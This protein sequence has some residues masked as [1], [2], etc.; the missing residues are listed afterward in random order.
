MSVSRADETELVCAAAR[1]DD[2]AFTEL[3]GRHA[4]ALF[5]HALRAT[6]N[7]DDAQDIVQDVF[8]IAFRRRKNIRVIDGSAAG[9]L[10]ATCRNT[11][12]NRLR[13]ARRRESTP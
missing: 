5:A 1:G 7:E 3:M 10:L 2:A 6:G 12:S 4:E 8:E 9:W 11:I 13:S